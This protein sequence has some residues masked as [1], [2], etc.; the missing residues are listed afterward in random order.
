M[1]KLIILLL[2]TTTGL[3]LRAQTR[4]SGLVKDPKGVFIPHASISIKDSYDGATSDSTGKFSFS[5]TDKGSRM[6][7]VTAVGYRGVE[8]AVSLEGLALS[9]EIVMKEEINEMK[10]VVIT[11]GTFEASDKKRATVLNSIDIFFPVSG[12]IC[13]TRVNPGSPHPACKQAIHEVQNCSVSTVQNAP[14]LIRSSPP[15]HWSGRY[16]LPQIMSSGAP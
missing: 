13:H 5:T 4:I 11:A 3:V 15:H 10:A 6:L 7:V 14:A 16:R 8:Q 2:F 9:L 1:R 12:K